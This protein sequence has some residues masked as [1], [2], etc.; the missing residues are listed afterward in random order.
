[1][2]K[3]LVIAYIV[4]IILIVLFSYILVWWDKNHNMPGLAEMMNIK[5][6]IVYLII[7]ILVFIVITITLI[8][9]GR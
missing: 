4:D 2:K 6:H 9:K 5:V 7:E 3:P 1:M 8:K